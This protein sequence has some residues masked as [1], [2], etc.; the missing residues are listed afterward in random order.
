MLGISLPVSSF[1]QEANRSNPSRTLNFEARK[2]NRETAIAIIEN[3]NYTN[4]N[5]MAMEVFSYQTEKVHPFKLYQKLIGFS[6]P[7][8]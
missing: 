7:W 8:L 1:V 2:M 6:V 5:E 3:T 4:F